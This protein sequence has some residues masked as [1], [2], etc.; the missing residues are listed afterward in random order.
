V[1][2]E[3]EAAGIARLQEAAQAAGGAQESEG[4]A[5]KGKKRSPPTSE[6]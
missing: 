6:T 2:V 4:K 1:I 5:R 3:N